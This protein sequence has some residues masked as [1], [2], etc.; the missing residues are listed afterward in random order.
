MVE[1]DQFDTGERMLLNFGHT[2]AHTIEQYFHYGRESHGEAVAIGMYQIT[3]LAE[4]KGL[5]PAGCAESIREVLEAYG[6][7]YECGVSLSDLTAAITLDKKNLNNRLNVVLLH[8]IG[9]SYVY[10]T[11]A[12]F[13]EGEFL[14]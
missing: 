11:D 7:P 9:D 10:P 12:G 1:A 5:T 14:V 6:L 2:L 13:F 4:E 3:K 8:E